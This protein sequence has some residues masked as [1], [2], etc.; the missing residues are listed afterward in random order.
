MN[1][2][3]RLGYLTAGAIAFALAPIAGPPPVPTFS[4][5]VG[6]ARLVDGQMRIT[7]AQL[8]TGP[9]AIE[10]SDDLTNWTRAVVVPSTGGRLLLRDNDTENKVRFYRVARLP[11]PAP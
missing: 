4:G 11:A 3:K 6:S 2:W 5:P 9:I 10:L 8:G 1:K 7:W